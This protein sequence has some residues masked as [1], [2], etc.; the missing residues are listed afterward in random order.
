MASRC[1]SLSRPSLSLLK[2]TITIPSV[3][4][5]R[6][7]SLLSPPFLRTLSRP[8]PHLGALQSLLPLH[9]AVSSARLTSCLGIDL[10]SRSLSQELGLGVLR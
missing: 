10:N 4:P 5:R 8:N 2:S 3:Q 6:T 9:S 7:P 1:R